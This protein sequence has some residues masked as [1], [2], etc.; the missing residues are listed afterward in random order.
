V[1][2]GCRAN[3]DIPAKKMSLSVSNETPTLN[4]KSSVIVN[5]LWAECLRNR[6]PIPRRD[7]KFVYCPNHLDHPRAYCALY[8]MG[9]R[10]FLFGVK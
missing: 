3:L 10:G 5:R 7:T 6:D 4:L 9:T 1:I 8:T 2:A